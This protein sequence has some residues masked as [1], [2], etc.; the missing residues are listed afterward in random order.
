MDDLK[1]KGHSVR[2]YVVS[3][4]GGVRNQRHILEEEAG[5]ADELQWKNFRID[6]AVDDAVRA[7]CAKMAE[8]QHGGKEP[9]KKAVRKK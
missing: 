7:E 6:K 4:S 8:E 3:E 1:S 9:W 5:S 2:V